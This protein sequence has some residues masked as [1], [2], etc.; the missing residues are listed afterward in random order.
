MDVA[1]ADLLFDIELNNI[2]NGA[3]CMMCTEEVREFSGCSGAKR[4]I[5]CKNGSMKDSHSGHSCSAI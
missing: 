3:H 4:C 5:T 2:F 1:V